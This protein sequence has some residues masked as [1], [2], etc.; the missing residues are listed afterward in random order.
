M[1]PCAR[2]RQHIYVL[3]DK[4]VRRKFAPPPTTTTGVKGGGAATTTAAAADDDDYD[5]DEDEDGDVH[6]A[7]PADERGNYIVASISE[8][9]RLVASDDGGAP[10]RW[11]GDCAGASFIAPA[12]ASR[13]SF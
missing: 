12:S 3:V 7:E 5:C 1:W 2:T 13:V 9:L 8:R 11:V 6:D 4:R 10:C